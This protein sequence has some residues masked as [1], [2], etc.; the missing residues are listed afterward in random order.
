VSTHDD[1]SLPA[2]VIV[3]TAIKLTPSEHFVIV[4]D[5]SSERIGDAIAEAAEMAGAWVR[6]VRLDRIAARPLRILPETARSALASAQASVF[7]ARTLH[8]EWH[9]RQELLHLVRERGL[10]HAH[11]AGVSEQAFS[12]GVRVSYDQIARTGEAMRRVVAKARTI[13]AE[14]DAGTQL[15]VTTD[16]AARWFSQL[17]VLS[18]GVWGS[19]PAGALYTSPGDISGTFVADASLGEFIGAREGLLAARPVTFTIERGVVTRVASPGAPELVREIE[20]LLALSP[21]S[22]RV[23]L[24]AI[25]VNHGIERPIG[26]A[27]VD[28]NFPG[29]HLGIGDPAGKTTGAAWRAQTC[30]AA[31]ESMSRVAVDGVD[32]VRAGRLVGPTRPRTASGRD[33]PAVQDERRSIT[34]SS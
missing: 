24:V 13:V 34:P 30:F 17:G 27:V 32:V 33:F 4:D 23:G 12:A 19:F 8:H 1:L 7:V 18:A 11:L 31:C 28:Q 20:A 10:R 15:F 16:P 26:D 25:G 22:S 6:R 5:A 2:N 3:R 14:S 21:N 29:L 9:M